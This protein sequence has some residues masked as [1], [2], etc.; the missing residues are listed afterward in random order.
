MSDVES[1]PDQVAAE[2]VLPKPEEKLL[3][4]K[5]SRNKVRPMPKNIKIAII[6]LSVVSVCAIAGMS[7][8]GL[9]TWNYG[10]ELD[11]TKI[12]IN[13]LKRIV[14]DGVCEGLTK[15]KLGIKNVDRTL[16]T[17][18]EGFIVGN[19]KTIMK[20]NSFGNYMWNYTLGQNQTFTYTISEGQADS[21]FVVLNEENYLESVLK[22]DKN[23]ENLW[24]TQLPI[25]KNWTTLIIGDPSGGCLLHG[26]VFNMENYSSYFIHFDRDGN[27]TFMIET[28]NF[29][30][31]TISSRG[32]HFYIVGESYAS[33]FRKMAVIKIDHKG[34]YNEIIQNNEALTTHGS[35]WNQSDLLIWYNDAD[36]VSV[37]Q[38]DEDGKQ[39]RSKHFAEISRIHECILALDGHIACTCEDKEGGSIHEIGP[40][41]N[42]VWGNRVSGM[43]PKDLDRTVKGNFIAIFSEKARASN[44]RRQK[45]FEIYENGEIYGTKEYDT[46][47][48]EIIAAHAHESGGIYAILSG[49]FFH[50]KQVDIEGEAVI[51]PKKIDLNDI[52]I[53]CGI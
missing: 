39:N 29:V 32:N 3:P 47:T 38:F 13:K 33:H 4:E 34:E 20:I 5:S 42:W 19:D 9:T 23:G 45:Y 28:E 50:G 7:V 25:G 16:K 10:N 43:V 17:E 44:T 22:L 21:L 1:N 46:K 15:T 12:E 31:R 49:A 24:N 18:D 30:G 11:I 37:Y 8:F 51:F 53:Y 48:E 35:F 6:I 14:Q 36:G 41:F 52:Q 27:Q 2:N 26:T 40:D